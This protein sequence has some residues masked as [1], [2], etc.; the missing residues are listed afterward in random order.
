VVLPSRYL[1]ASDGSASSRTRNTSSSETGQN[2][3]ERVETPKEPPPIHHMMDTS[4]SCYQQRSMEG[5]SIIQQQCETT[6]GNCESS[7]KMDCRKRKLSFQQP[8]SIPIINLEPEPAPQPSS[9]L[10]TGASDDLYLDDD[11][12]EGLD[13]DAIEA[14]ATEQWKQKTAQSTQKLV[15]PKRASEISFAPPSF[16]LGF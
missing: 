11:F 8:A 6:T 9:H 2:S 15:E 10:V 12:F 16:D 4:P 5:A 13:L 14:Q 1:D 7:S 3:V